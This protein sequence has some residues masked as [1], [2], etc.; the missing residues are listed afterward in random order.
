MNIEGMLNKTQIFK[1]LQL[2][3]KILQLLKGGQMGSNL[4]GTDSG[5]PC[6]NCILCQLKI[7]N[8]TVSVNY[9]QFSVFSWFRAT[10]CP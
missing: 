7:G 10:E 8:K 5:L 3:I 1:I 9:V 2:N 4:D 6:R